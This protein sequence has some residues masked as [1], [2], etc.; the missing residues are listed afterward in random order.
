MNI[1]ILGSGKG[2]NCRAILNAHSAGLFNSTNIAAICSDKKESGILEIARKECI[3]YSCFGNYDSSDRN[4]D[5]KWIDGIK[6]YNPDLIVLAGFMKILSVHFIENFKS[7][8]I[9]LHPSILPSFRGLSAIKQA[10]DA[11]VKITGCT[12]HW[13][14]PEL[15]S[16]KIIAQAPVRIM[17]GDT[18][19]SVSAKVSGAEHMLLPTVIAELSHGLHI[20]ND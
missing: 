11:G 9:N 13:V 18:L 2:S 7:K 12:V 17:P 1:V 8:I 15:D 16:G 19:E 4:I 20:L 5:N 3:P 10:W 6:A 14:T